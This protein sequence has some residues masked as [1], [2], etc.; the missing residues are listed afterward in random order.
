[1]TH[2]TGLAGSKRGTR[3]AGPGAAFTLVELLVVIG[4]IAL[5]VSILLPS[6]GKA[7]RSANTAKCLVN[8]RSLG[9]A[10]VMYAADW[11]GWAIPPIL[12]NEVDVWPGTS[13]K[14]RAVW[15]DN[16][17]LRA[18]LGM[19]LWVPGSGNGGRVPG[20]FVC[21]EAIQANEKQ[22]NPHG[23]SIGYSYGYNAR[24]L[25]YVGT[26]IYTLPVAKT[27]DV[28]TEFAG[29]KITRVRSPSNK[30]MFADAMTPH[31]QPQHSAHFFRVQG[32]DE[33]RD[34]PDETAFVAYRHSPR[35]DRI[36]VVFWDGH[37][38]TLDRAE[39][40]AVKDPN[41]AATNGPVANRTPAWDRAWELQV[42]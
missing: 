32:F 14:K 35:H 25:N 18:A 34:Q 12:G 15:F 24:H 20:G 7:R 4:I 21:P 38:E 33:W 36:N 42:P 8:L 40:E 6:L 41:T 13:V 1:M 39:V 28:N 5:L 10:Q 9:Q 30:I 16:N 37:A 31:L 3:T 11:K 2:V 19:P 26:P 23:T 29:V 27:W 22:V 17:A